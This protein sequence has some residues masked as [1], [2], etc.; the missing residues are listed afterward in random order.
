MAG[1]FVLRHQVSTRDDTRL[2]DH[3]ST[4]EPAHYDHYEE[5]DPRSLTWCTRSL[6]FPDHEGR[7]P[8]DVDGGQ[9]RGNTGAATEGGR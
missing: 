2:E 4:K 7:R 9:D 1:G 5:V 8:G 3:S 6:E